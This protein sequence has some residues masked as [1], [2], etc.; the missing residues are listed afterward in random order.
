MCF[1]YMESGVHHSQRC[2][3]LGAPC[4]GG[5]SKGSADPAPAQHTRSTGVVFVSEDIRK[6]RELLGGLHTCVY[7]LHM[8]AQLLCFPTYIQAQPHPPLLSRSITLTLIPKYRPHGPLLTHRC[9]ADSLHTYLPGHICTPRRKSCRAL[10]SWPRATHS[11]PR[12]IRAAVRSCCSAISDVHPC[13]QL[14]AG[15][16]D[17]SKSQDICFQP[18]LPQNLNAISLLF[19]VPFS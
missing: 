19:G 2:L 7:V 11:S 1:A 17:L 15:P 14:E 18:D 5:S 9:T 8:S 4:P 13:S 3:T 6:P 10:V 12:L 16:G